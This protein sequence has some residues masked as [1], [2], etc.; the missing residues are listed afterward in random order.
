LIG[1]KHFLSKKNRSTEK[2]YYL[3]IPPI[4]LRFPAIYLRFPPF[5]DQLFR[6]IYHLKYNGIIKMRTPEKRVVVWIDLLSYGIVALPI[7]YNLYFHEQELRH[8]KVMCSIEAAHICRHS[9]L[10]RSD[11]TFVFEEISNGTG[12]V[13]SFEEDLRNNLYYDMMLNVV[14]DYIVFKEDFSTR[15]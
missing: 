4:Y 14:A 2:A 5:N 10:C 3:K 15:V 9:W 12:Y 6:E 1:T 8:C 13:I 11:F 7:V